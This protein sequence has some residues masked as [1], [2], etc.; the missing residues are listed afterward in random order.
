[1][2]QIS[3]KQTFFVAIHLTATSIDPEVV[4]LWQCGIVIGHRTI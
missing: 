2:R 3:G 4:E 1:M